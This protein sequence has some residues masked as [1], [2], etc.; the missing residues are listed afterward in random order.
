MNIVNGFPA[1]V[2]EMIEGCE[3][4]SLSFTR[5]RYRNPWELLVG[6]FHKGPV[7]VVGDAMH[8]MGPFLGQGG[9]A[10]ME[11]AVVLARN[12]A[13]K[14]STPDESEKGRQVMSHHRI[15]EEAFDQYVNERRMR[16]V[17]LST[18]T[19]LIG[20]ILGTKSS[21]VK[22]IAIIILV[23]LFRD[24]TAHTKYDCGKL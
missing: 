13:Q 18:Q 12:L 14:F 22:F 9:S 4:D 10:A 2:G 21:V 19:Y 7:T 8:V 24:Q 23:V 1:D 6:K 11:D 20:V 16:I 3:L 17:R 5:L 15:V